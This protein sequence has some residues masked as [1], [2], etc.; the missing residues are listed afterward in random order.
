MARFVATRRTLVPVCAATP[1]F[2]T[3]EVSR[4]TER[5]GTA[6]G[7]HTQLRR[8]C[9]FAAQRLGRERP[10]FLTP[11]PEIADR[12]DHFDGSRE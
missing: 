7:Q 12:F 11:F 8:R 3:A 10:T 4:E 1:G 2:R 9:N 5:L 6:R